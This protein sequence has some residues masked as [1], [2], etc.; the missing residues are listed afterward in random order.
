MPIFTSSYLNVFV[1]KRCENF[2]FA[3]EVFLHYEIQ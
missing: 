2:T 1:T 3:D